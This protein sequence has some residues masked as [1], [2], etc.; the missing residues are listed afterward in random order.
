MFSKKQKNM[1]T[2]SRNLPLSPS[3]SLSFNTKMT[4]LVLGIILGIVGL[5]VALATAKGYDA[6]QIINS[7]K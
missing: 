1:T 3:I 2:I 6:S 5:A 4:L 7:L